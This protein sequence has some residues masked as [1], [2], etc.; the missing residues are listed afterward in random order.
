MKEIKS[1][2][3]I[4]LLENKIRELL[5]CESNHYCTFLQSTPYK[6]IVILL[7]LQINEIISSS[8]E[9]RLN[10]GS[11]TMTFVMHSDAKTTEILSNDFEGVFEEEEED[12]QCKRKRKY[13][14]Q[15]KEDS[16][17]SKITNRKKY[18][19]PELQS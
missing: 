13:T 2:T 4:I 16:F 19:P 5:Q 17:I 18:F 11:N 6:E 8:E 15:R 3:D 7:L 1:N 9:I 14:R 10:F 12:V